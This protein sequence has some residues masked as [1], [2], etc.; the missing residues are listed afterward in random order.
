MLDLSATSR[1][2]PT[3]AHVVE[4][5]YLRYSVE[6]PLAARLSS[7][8]L[9]GEHYLLVGSQRLRGILQCKAILSHGREHSL[10][11]A[12]LLVLHGQLEG[13]EATPTGL[14][15]GPRCTP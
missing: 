11:V 2:N 4:P 9:R 6:Q 15:H 1:K 5:F 3:L 10:F 12:L 7:V 13:V 8:L 14:P